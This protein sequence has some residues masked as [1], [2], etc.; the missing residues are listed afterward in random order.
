[1][2]TKKVVIISGNDRVHHSKKI[3]ATPVHQTPT[4]IINDTFFVL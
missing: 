1:M 2:T 4:I 3:L